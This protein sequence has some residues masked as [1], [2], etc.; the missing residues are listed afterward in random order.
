VCRIGSSNNSQQANCAG[1]AET[2]MVAGLVCWCKQ[3]LGRACGVQ[4]WPCRDEQFWPGRAVV[5]MPIG[6]SGGMYVPFY[7]LCAVLV[8]HSQGCGLNQGNC[9]DTRPS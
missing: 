2:L 7:A 5:M 9:A 1:A 8:L 4:Q 3:V 6:C